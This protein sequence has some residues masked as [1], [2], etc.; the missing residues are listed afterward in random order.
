MGVSFRGETLSIPP[1]VARLS[2]ACGLIRGFASPPHGGFA[3]V[4]K[5]CRS[6]RLRVATLVP[7]RPFSSGPTRSW[8]SG[9]YGSSRR[10]GQPGCEREVQTLTA[11]L[12]KNGVWP[13][14]AAWIVG[15]LVLL[16]SGCAS[17]SCQQASIKVAKKE[18]RAPLEPTPGG[19]TSETARRQEVPRP[20][21][22]RA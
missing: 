5:V 6:C 15:A 1:S 4:G 13:G 2:G 8:E 16:V 9:S 20:E 18:E 3:F 10:A 7:D 12:P 21:R 22:A 19:D 14:L 11:G 17:L